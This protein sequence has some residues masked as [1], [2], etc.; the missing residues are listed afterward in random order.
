MTPLSIEIERKFLIACLP[1]S[2]GSQSGNTIRQG[3]LIATENGIELR[4]RQKAELFFQTIKLGEGL[5]RT[6]IEIELSADQFNALWPHTAGR[7]VRKTRYTLPLGEQTAEVDRFEGD[8][9]G[10]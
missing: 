1:S 6:E 8:L 10:T 2:L 9:A 3:Y 5:S 7:R 4:I